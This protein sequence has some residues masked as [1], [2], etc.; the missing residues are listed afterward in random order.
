MTGRPTAEPRRIL[1]KLSGQ[2]LKGEDSAGISPAAVERMARAIAAVREDGIE[3]A[4][5]IGGGNIF[6][7]LGAETRGMDRVTADSMGMLATLINALAVQE[8][9]EKLGCHTRLMSAITVRQVAEPF[10]RRR[11]LRHLEK[12]RI[13]LF[14]AGTGNPYFS[15]DT[16]A[17]LRANEIRADVLIKAT[18]VDGVF[19]GDPERDPEATPIRQLTY[20]EAIRQELRFM[21]TTA[22]SLCMENDLPIVV[23]HQD[24][25]LEAARGA[26]AGTRVE[27]GTD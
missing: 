19:T 3:A 2:A 25:I 15:T 21:D 5:V 22:I 12:G 14:A 26:D 6:R 8:A 1:L 11:A 18:R 16:A 4:C 17:A 7:G 9:L 10:I 27:K 23:C 24:D 13:V 20:L